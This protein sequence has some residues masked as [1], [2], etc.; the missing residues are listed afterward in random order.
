MHNMYR[1]TFCSSAVLVLCALGSA[2]AGAGD[3]DPLFTAGF[4]DLSGSFELDEAASGTLSAIATAEAGEGTSA[5]SGD[6]TRILAPGG[7]ALFRPGFVGGPTLGD[8]AISMQIF[9]IDEQSALGSGSFIVTDANGD[10]LSGTITGDWTRLPGPFG[11]F[12]GLADDVQFTDASGD[13]TFDGP[14]GGSFAT[15]FS[16]GPPFAGAFIILETLGWFTEDFAGRTVQF[17]SA[18]VPEPASAMVLVPVLVLGW[19]V[20]RRE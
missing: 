17:S 18:F 20:S 4:N 3:I 1:S 13:A 15:Q 12:S 6:V 19:R 8:V 14:D 2:Y 9:D 16:S 11:S 7:T 10:T 5:T